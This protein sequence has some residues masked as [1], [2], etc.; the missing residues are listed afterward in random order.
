MYAAKVLPLGNVK[1]FRQGLMQ[2]AICSAEDMVGPLTELLS[3]DHIFQ[4]GLVE[5]SQTAL[6]VF[7]AFGTYNVGL[8]LHAKLQPFFEVYFPTASDSESKVSAEQRLS[9][10]TEITPW[11]A[12]HD[13]ALLEHLQIVLKFTEVT[14]VFSFFQTNREL[15]ALH[16]TLYT[17]ELVSCANPSLHLIKQPVVLD[18]ARAITARLVTL[19]EG[20]VI[21]PQVVG[22]DG[23]V[24]SSWLAAVTKVVMAH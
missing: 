23:V 9:S 22:S 2:I 13:S 4:G 17:S 16:P 11:N 7:S 18:L 10:P 12:V 5:R 3:T 14:S 1:V 15:S 6:Y 19:A 20:V 21:A 8:V 24:T